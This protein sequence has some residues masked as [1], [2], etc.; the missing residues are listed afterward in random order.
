[1][2]R[3]LYIWQAGYPWE[4]RVEKFCRALRSAGA[5]ITVL[6]RWVPGQPALEEHEGIRIVR[7]G[8]GLP[9]FASMPVPVNPLWY[10][11]ISREVR[12]WQPDLVLA[13][14][15]LLAEPAG[16]VCRRHSVPLVIDMAE[17]YPASMRAWKKYRHNP[18]LKFL[19]FHLRLPDRIERRSLHWADG[20]ITVCE[21]Q[22]RRLHETFGY[23]W[24]RMTVVEN[25][26]DL[27]VFHAVRQ[28]VSDPARVFA[29]HG[30]MT[31]QRGLTNLLQG[32][33]LAARRDPEIRLLLAGGGESYD[34]LVA[35]ARSSGVSERVRFTGR[36]RFEE[37]GKLYG[38]TD[39]G[40]VL[41]PPD[42]SCDHTIPNKLYDYLACGK[43][44]LVS[45][46]RPLRRVVEQTRTGL[47]LESCAP[48]VIARGIERLRGLD[49]R[50]LSANGVRACRER[51]H[52]GHDT[53]VLLDFLQ[54]CSRGGLRACRRQ[55]LPCPPSRETLP[56]W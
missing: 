14:E 12:A 21:E 17:H 39:V 56:T 43:P 7:V 13:R 18:L 32:F 10:S 25:T 30:H 49:L 33:I 51:Y 1:M 31:A 8:A 19:V 48:E 46:A 35:V 42:E 3:I 15:I 36:Y 9:R 47:A 40:L 55:S 22:N 26:P 27:G 28:G 20:V 11:A 54:R 44:V 41:Q 2:R 6:A 16:R 37:R 53:G 5:E 4:V 29:Y 23:P 52:W 34:E 45:P 24:A 50:E 38:E